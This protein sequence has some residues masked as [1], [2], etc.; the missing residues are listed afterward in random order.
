MACPSSTLCVTG[1]NTGLF[2]STHPLE[3]SGSWRQ[4]PTQA[5]AVGLSCPSSLLCY[6]V[7]AG[8]VLS[9][10]RPGDPAAA[11]RL[12]PIDNGAGTC[13]VDHEDQPCPFGLTAISCPTKNFCAA[14]DSGGYAYTSSHPQRG[15][16]SWKR[17]SVD[18]NGQLQD[19]QGIP[20]G[21]ACPSVNL[22]VGI[23]HYAGNVFVSRDPTGGASAWRAAQIVEGHAVFG[24]PIAITCPLVSRCIIATDG[25]GVLASTEPANTAAG[26]TT[27]E[28]DPGNQLTGLTCPT[29]K[30]CVAVDNQGNVIIGTWTRSQGRRRAAPVG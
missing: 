27:S 16:S 30:R 21:L 14:L 22:C 11:W 17:R 6:G 26:W 8:D 20:N 19:L 25:G 9:S 5:S 3:R 1:A 24:A 23:D 7:I 29:P 13:C 18:Q 10:A 12:T 28:I 2:A 15:R 4:S